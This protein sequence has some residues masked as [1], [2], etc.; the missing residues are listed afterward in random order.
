MEII[1]GFP[2]TSQ[3][4]SQGKMDKKIIRAEYEDVYS[5]K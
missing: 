4:S 3:N 1:E 5:G 2:A